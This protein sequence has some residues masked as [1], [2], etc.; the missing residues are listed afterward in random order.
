MTDNSDPDERR[1]KSSLFGNEGGSSVW[2]RWKRSFDLYAKRWKRS[3][4]LYALAKGIVEDSQKIAFLFIYTAGQEVQDLHHKLVGPGNE[5]RDF[6][7]VD[8]DVVP[9]VNAPFKRHVFQAIREMP[10]RQAE[11][12][13]SGENKRNFKRPARHCRSS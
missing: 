5:L 7:D 6:K 10:K 11:A 9:K 8:G 2:K 12:V 4:D 13:V 3:F 1:T